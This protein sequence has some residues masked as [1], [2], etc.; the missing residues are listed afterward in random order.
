MNEASSR[1]HAIMTITVVEQRMN[2]K[3]NKL[4]KKTSKLHI[5]DL[6]GSERAETVCGSGRAVKLN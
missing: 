3:V 2:D 5:V 6:A 1:S 4:I